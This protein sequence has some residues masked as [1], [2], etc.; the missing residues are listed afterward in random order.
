M[1]E[2]QHLIL[3]AA[4][5]DLPTARN[6]F[7]V[8]ADR[9]KRKR[10]EIRDALLVT[11]DADG[12]PRVAEAGSHLGRHG[13]GWGVGLGILVGLFVPPMAAT[14]ALG[15]AAGAAFAKFADHELRTG[16]RH[17]VGK[18]LEMG[19][20]VAIVLLPPESELPARR[21]LG[22]SPAITVLAMEDSTIGSVEAAVADELRLSAR[23]STDNPGTSSSR[24]SADNP[25][26]SS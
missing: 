24:A 19:T 13:A 15:A 9:V 10:F 14:M 7:G 12:R 25:G 3:I 20:G 17:E 6:D 16:L 26:T 11:K 21:A 18:A 5:L 4:Y 22:T 8:L 1:K 23:A 2:S